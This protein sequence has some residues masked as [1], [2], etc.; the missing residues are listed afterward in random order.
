VSPWDLVE[1]PELEFLM[2]GP[3]L[4]VVFTPRLSTMAAVGRARF[5]RFT[6][7]RLTLASSNRRR[8]VAA[9]ESVSGR[10]AGAIE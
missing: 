3:L 2:K 6:F 1:I 10:F 7:L 4:S 8:L 9:T 5:R